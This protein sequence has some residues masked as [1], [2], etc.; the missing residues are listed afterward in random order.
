MAD[1]KTW[2]EYMVPH[3]QL[4]K[5]LLEFRQMALLIDYS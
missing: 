5:D 1:S 2:E 4:W 3:K